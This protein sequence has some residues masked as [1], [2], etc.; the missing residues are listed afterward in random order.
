MSQQSSGSFEYSAP[1]SVSSTDRSQLLSTNCNCWASNHCL[2]HRRL[3]SH[4]ER[5]VHRELHLLSLRSYSH[6]WYE[7]TDSSSASAVRNLVSFSTQ[8]TSLC[9]RRLVVLYA[10]DFQLVSSTLSALFH[11]LWVRSC[12]FFS[13]AVGSLFSPAVRPL[14]SFAVSIM[15]RVVLDLDHASVLDFS[16]SLLA[17]C[18]GI[19]HSFLLGL[20]Y[21]SA[22]FTQV[23]VVDGAAADCLTFSSVCLS[24]SHALRDV[25][26]TFHELLR[27]VRLCTACSHTCC[28]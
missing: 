4:N 2:G 21:E 15:H 13:S 22:D 10:F 3:S 19:I 7:T 20:V 24:A 14:F 28:A 8:R 25:I 9:V 26:M 6:V 17:S 1:V 18:L 27:T 16:L 11:P 12:Q 23:L 5:Y